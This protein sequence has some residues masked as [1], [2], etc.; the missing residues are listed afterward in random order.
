MIERSEGNDTNTSSEPMDGSAVNRSVMP[1]AVELG[2]ALIAR[3][4]KLR[5]EALLG[6]LSA[7]QE[8]LFDLSAR[9][10]QRHWAFDETIELIGEIMADAATDSDEAT[11]ASS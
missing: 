5:Q 1:T 3:L 2:E 7:E 10:W 8:N 11:M 6:A 9:R 4:T